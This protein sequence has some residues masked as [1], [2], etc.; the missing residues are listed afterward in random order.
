MLQCHLRSVFKDC[1]VCLDYMCTHVIAIFKTFCCFGQML[2][3]HIIVEEVFL[4]TITETKTFK[5]NL[6]DDIDIVKDGT[7]KLLLQHCD[8]YFYLHCQSRE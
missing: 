4:D 7:G 5:T 8:L 6:G 2:Q 1:R 3:R